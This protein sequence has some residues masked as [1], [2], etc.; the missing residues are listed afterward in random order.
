MPEI[1]QTI[2]HYRIL[3][4]LGQGGM[5]EVYLAEDFS[6]D[7]KVA[8]KFLPDVS[9]GDPVRKARF[10][11]EAKLLA[12]LNHPNIAAIYGLEQ[13]D[14]KRFLVLEYVEG[15]TLQQSLGKGPLPVEDTLG[16]CRQIAEGLEAAHES[17]VIHRD[18]KPANVMITTEEKVKILDFGLAKALADEVQSV[19]SSH[20]PTITEAMTQPGV[21]LGTAAYM[22]PEQAKG[23]AVDK[24][25]DIWAFGSILYEC[26]TGK[27]AFR[28]NNITEILAK[29]LEAEPDWSRLPA[30]TPAFMKSVL[31]Q[32]L[33]KDPKFRLHDI[34][35]V[36]IQMGETAA[37][38]TVPMEAVSA[39]RRPSFFWLTACAAVA[40]VAGIFI[41]SAL[42]TRY[43]Q[44]ASPAP[45][46]TSTIKVEPGHWLEGMHRAIEMDRPSR[47][48]MTI[49]SNGKFIVYSA[50]EKNPG[51]QAK[52]QLYLRKMDQSEAKVITGTE[53]GINPFLSP[54]DRWIG[55]W[56]DGKLKKVPVEGG[57]AATLCDASTLY[58]ANWGRDN[59][60]AFAGGEST[61]ISI[62]SAEGGTPEILTK[63]DPKREEYGHRPL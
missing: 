27:Q 41:G 14:G 50:I 19:E 26:L 4:K 52:P 1:G 7:R 48:A 54:D 11:R 47:T 56:A 49:S 40:F 28:G 37:M 10:E 45:V 24:R 25:T 34:A 60:I 62:V 2:S 13:A 39:F 21:V 17:G 33:Q 59:S 3:E 6:L 55:F 9:T 22:S 35:D 8:L 43:F 53:G 12:S 44:P 31:R 46:V 51:V 38:D 57:I 15:E 42:T 32:C 5:G 29:I 36:R 23:R 20:S 30:H 61:G 16:V 58:G 63:P 18:L